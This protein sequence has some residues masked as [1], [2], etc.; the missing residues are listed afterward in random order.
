M[1]TMSTHGL[2]LPSSPRV[3]VIYCPESVVQARETADLLGAAT[4][5]IR[6]AGSRGNS[7]GAS[8]TGSSPVVM[9]VDDT[10]P[11]YAVIVCFADRDGSL[12]PEARVFLENSDLQGKLVLPLIDCRNEGPG[13]AASDV[14]KASGGATIG[15]A[16]YLGSKDELAPEALRSWLASQGLKP[17]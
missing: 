14:G 4:F 13:H 7:A 5:E 8:E 2:S 17:I 6:P 10:D 3:L 9:G 16:F 1:T 15:Q 12:P 11:Y